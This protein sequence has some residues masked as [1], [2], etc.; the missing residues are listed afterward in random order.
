[1]NREHHVYLVPGM[2]GFAQLAGYDYFGHIRKALEQR[3]ADRGLELHVEVVS[4][5]PTSSLRHRARIL[6]RAIDAHSQGQATIHIVGHSTGGLDARLL[7]AP[8]ADI[9]VAAS[10][11]EW[12]SR[13]SSVTTINTPHYG[14]P[15][16]SYFA[17]V[18]GTRVLYALSLL[19][20][21]SLSLGTNSL[22]VFARL[23]ASLGGIDQI[24]GGDF[25]LIGRVTDVL[26][27]Y[28]DSEGRQTIETYLNKMRL[29]Q[30]AIIQITPEAMDVFNAATAND[31]R[32]RYGCAASAAP[33]PT[34]WDL[35]RRIRSPYA[36]LTAA[37]FSTLYTV[38]SQRHVRYG[39]ANP[40]VQQSIGLTRGLG[41]DID[42]QSNDA[43]VP[44]RS[45]LW[46]NLI[47]CGPGDHLDVI[48][49]FHGGRGVTSHV[50]W[51]TSG[52]A[53][54]RNRFAELMDSV[55]AFQL[56]G[57]GSRQLR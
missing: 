37:M 8:S 45:M 35:G 10:Q 16:A 33:A 44:T 24:F 34:P 12:R 2:F 17:T 31:A 38:T 6:A 27:R 54:D 22:S 15:L 36:A 49:H 47:W 48:G 20:V 43:V 26:L 56:A 19:T 1:M 42:E 28:V 52:A 29:D 13:V 39:Y 40:D 25:K 41:T 7:L 30:G 53:F 11:L 5:P 4:P 14:T 57:S 55:T 51:M 18:S 23:F 32:V 3:Y 46:G 21:V 9:K 50:D